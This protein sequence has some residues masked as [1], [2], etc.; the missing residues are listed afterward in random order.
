M[1]LCLLEETALLLDE[2]RIGEVKTLAQELAKVFESKRVHREALAAFG[3]F[4]D[5]AEREEATARLARRVLGYLFR[6]RY[7]QGLRLNHEPL[8]QPLGSIPQPSS[9]SGSG[10]GA[11]AQWR[12]SGS[13]P[14]PSLVV[15]SLAKEE[16]T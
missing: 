11:A 6:A 16:S 4:Q 2:G 8:G 3:L 10:C 9:V 1:A 5:A 12:P 13:I 15:G 14:Q 7:D